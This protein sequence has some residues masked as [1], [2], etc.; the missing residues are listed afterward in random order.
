M[1]GRLEYQAVFFIAKITDFDI[2]ADTYTIFSSNC[3]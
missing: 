1:D 3:E 2:I